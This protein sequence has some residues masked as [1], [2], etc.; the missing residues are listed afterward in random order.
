MGANVLAVEPHKMFPCEKRKGRG[1]EDAGDPGL[2]LN[3]GRI[4]GALL[5]LLKAKTYPLGE[6]K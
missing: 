1:A 5:D 2:K 6:I 4:D 3:K